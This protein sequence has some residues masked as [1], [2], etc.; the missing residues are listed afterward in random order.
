MTAAAATEDLRNSR[1]DDFPIRPP[2]LQF[3]QVD[4]GI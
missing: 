3:T 2:L 4:P 1:R